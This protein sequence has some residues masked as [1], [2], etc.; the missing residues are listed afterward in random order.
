MSLKIAALSALLI[1]S[2]CSG[3]GNGG[4]KRL[5]EGVSQKGPFITGTSLQIQELDSDLD[6]TGRTSLGQIVDD[7]GTFTVSASL[8]SP[9]VE[10]VATGYYFDEI[11]G[12]LSPATLSLRAL[13]NVNE[14]VAVNLN[15]L[16]TLEKKRVIHLVEAGAAF[17]EAKQQAQ[18]EILSL[19]TIGGPI[20]PNSEEMSITETGDAN[21]ILLAVS[22]ILQATARD[23][24][25][26]AANI[27][28]ELSELLARIEADLEL[29]GD[30]DDAEI[31]S[32]LS[33]AARY[34]D[35]ELV[36]S[37]LED[38]YASLGLIVTVPAFEEF[39]DSDGDGLI[40]RDDPVPPGA[41]ETI[42]G[43]PGAH[44][45]SATALGDGRLLLAGGAQSGNSVS[46]AWL[47]DEAAEAVMTTGALGTPR[48]FH[49]AALTSDGKVLV[50][51]GGGTPEALSTE[52]YDP[53]AGSFSPGPALG[54]ARTQATATSLLDGRIL[55][56]GGL[57]TDGSSA[58]VYEDGSFTPLP[59]MSAERALHTATLLQDGR[60][61][62]VGGFSSALEETT[63]AQLFDPDLNVF[64]PT[65]SLNIPRGAHTATLL[66]SGEVVIA[67]G[68]RYGPDE[69]L[70]SVEIY[71]PVGGVFTLAEP[72]E[73]ARQSA[74]AALIDGRVHII[75]GY[76]ASVALSSTE[77]FDSTTLLSR[78]GAS[79]ATARAYC[80][81]TA[82]SGAR[83]LVSGG[84]DS[85][86]I[87]TAEL[88]GE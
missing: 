71:D 28:A 43:N 72:L 30:L 8:S 31:E 21:A 45:Q 27:T 56:T 48:V 76:A 26:S 54:E 33:R 12:A 57:N 87:V 4:T 49:V 34:L 75:G 5:I 25:S 85:G 24:A 23:R 66:P 68:F 69:V 15:V 61:L 6:S 86:S 64:V 77:V 32:Q 16:T 47:F 44:A 52:I 67:G 58:E 51:G 83:I 80:S 81:A 41:F 62:I 20:L 35:L 29:D 74:C 40:N 39:V 46:T 14:V 50:I 10:V 88:Y 55:V 11:G 38:R 60:V 59:S 65:G 53:A 19:F 7:L 9:R 79:L 22:A 37:N 1:C 2:G 82:L 18:A 73:E 63:S 70:S 84:V 36:R 3:G 42:P 13:A 78:R 17:A